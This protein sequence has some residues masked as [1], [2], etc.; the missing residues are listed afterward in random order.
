MYGTHTAS[1]RIASTCLPSSRI[2]KF[3]F[4][5]RINNQVNEILSA[6]LHGKLLLQGEG[7]DVQLKVKSKVYP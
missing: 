4:S 6:L 1:V 7:K 2:S 3:L 5:C